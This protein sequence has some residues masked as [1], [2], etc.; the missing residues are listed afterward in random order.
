ML[1]LTVIHCPLLGEPRVFPVRVNEDDPLGALDI[2]AHDVLALPKK[3]EL[4]HF[5]LTDFEPAPRESKY[6]LRDRL[7]NVLGEIIEDTLPLAY[8]I[9]FIW[10]NGPSPNRIHIAVIESNLVMR[11]SSLGALP[12]ELRSR[13]PAVQNRNNNLMHL[14]QLSAP[15]ECGKNPVVIYTHPATL[16]GRPLGRCGPPVALYNSHL[17][18]LTDALADLHCGPAPSAWILEQTQELIRLSLAFYTTEVERENAIRPVIDRIFPGAKWQYRLEGGSAKPEAIWDGQ[19]FELKNERG[20]SGDPTAQTIADYEKIVDSVDPAK[21]EEI[22]HFR[23]RSVLPL[24]LLSLASTQFEV[25]AAIYTDVAQV[26]HLF[27]INLHD[28]MHLEDQ[29]LCLARVLAVLQTTMTCLKTYYT[30]LRTEPTRP[31][32]YSSAL[33]LPSPISAEQPFEQITTALNL[34]FLYKLSRLTGVAIDPL[35]DGD[36]QAN[37]RHAVF[38]ALGGGHNS[39]PEGHEVIVKFARR[40]NVE[41]HE[42]LAGMNLAPKLYYHCSVRG[43]LVMVVMERVTGMMASHWSYLQGTPLPHFV[44]EDTRRAIGA[45]HDRNIV[46]GDLRLPNIMICDNRAVLVDFDWAAPAGQ[47]RYPA[48]LSDLDVWAPTVAPYGVMEK[49]HDDHML[50]AIA[51]ASVP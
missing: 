36:W 38:V 49:E 23:D 51:A 5:K 20:S 6:G 9:R 46:F 33:H 25:C 48:T 4:F 27:S 3:T 21:P 34:R 7:L 1:Y 28:S 11:M 41:A 14:S 12:V 39:I 15:S 8:S 37:T 13:Y 50:K 45:L 22:G 29:V 2:E 32:E 47:G 30:A 17:A 19:V 26:D 43:R 31:L 16:A 35:L 10:P 44:L 42:L 24:V 40:Y 18:A